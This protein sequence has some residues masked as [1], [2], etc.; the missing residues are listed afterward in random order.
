MVA[1]DSTPRSEPTNDVSLAQKGY[2]SLS[3]DAEVPDR[4]P[5]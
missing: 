3:F 2:G 1:P 5:G 4:A